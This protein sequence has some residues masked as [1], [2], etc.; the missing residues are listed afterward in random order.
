M[1]LIAYLATVLSQK[2]CVGP[3]GAHFRVSACILSDK[4]MNVHCVYR[5]NVPWSLI[6]TC[7]NTNIELQMWREIRNIRWQ[8]V[9]QHIAW[10]FRSCCTLQLLYLTWWKDIYIH[11]LDVNVSSTS[12]ASNM[13]RE[14]CFV[15][16]TTKKECYSSYI[17]IQLHSPFGMI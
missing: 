11:W 2:K 5:T 16:F 7:P 13:P 8:I 17:Y 10:C 3:Y 1:W 4:D 9:S 12:S 14:N 15:S 6:E